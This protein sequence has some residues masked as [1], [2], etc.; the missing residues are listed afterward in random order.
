M[1]TLVEAIEISNHYLDNNT[2]FFWWGPPGAGKSQGIHQL[3]LARKG[4][5]FID[6]RAPLREAVDMRGLPW[7]D[8]K[9][10]KTKWLVPDELP[11][12]KRDGKEGVFLLDEL[13]AAPPAVQVACFGLVLDRKVGDYTMPD[14]WRIAA[15]GNEQK[16]RAA[17]QKMPSA[18]ANRFAHITIEPDPYVWI[19]WANANGIDPILS[20]FIRF[21]PKLIHDMA[22]T[23]LRAFPTPRA[24][25]QVSKYVRIKNERIRDG[26]ISGLVGEG[27]TLELSGFISAFTNLPTLEEIV[28]QPKKA[29]VPDEAAGR[30]AVSGAIAR[31]ADRQNF[32]AI[33][34][35]AERLGKE[36]ET[37]TVIDAVKR[38]DSLC[39][40]PAYIAFKTANQHFEL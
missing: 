33:L 40:T 12:E 27:P 30:F 14:G 16:H 35:Y 6:F 37:C 34:T 1:T 2:P 15:A 19:A 23:D 21:R 7:V 38:D 36:F 26:A 25:E 9:T 4:W 29:K 28:D 10:W 24:W 17:A 22:G 3:R 13:N 18:L 39:S 5:G 11:N 8:Q 32:K 20:A 31:H